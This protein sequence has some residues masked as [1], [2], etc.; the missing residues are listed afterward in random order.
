MASDTLSLHQPE[1]DQ[2]S[3][4]QQRNRKSAALNHLLPPSL[5]AKY[6]P[7]WGLV[8]LLQYGKRVRETYVD[9]MHAAD[10][11][12]AKISEIWTTLAY[13]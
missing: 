12:K 9:Y 6:P 11:C 5:P 10:C 1:R 3:P 7:G 13:L 4:R 8:K 2:Y